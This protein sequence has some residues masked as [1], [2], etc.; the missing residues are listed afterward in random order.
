MAP[1]KNFI[2]DLG[3]LV[4]SPCESDRLRGAM[5]RAAL[6][7]PTPVYFEDEPGGVG[8]C[9]VCAEK[10]VL[11]RCPRCGVLMH[12]FCVAPELPG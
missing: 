10:G 5:L 9:C 6:D 2:L 11:G 7:S 12:C 8:M 4:A 1:H 3:A